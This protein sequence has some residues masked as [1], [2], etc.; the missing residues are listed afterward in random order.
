M[1][2]HTTPA[3]SAPGT[4]LWS[5]GRHR[6]ASPERCPPPPCKDPRK[7]SVRGSHLLSLVSV[8]LGRRSQSSTAAAAA[9][10]APADASR[11]PKRRSLS[12]KSVSFFEATTP[13]A[14]KRRTFKSKR[15]LTFDPVKAAQAK[16]KRPSR[17]SGLL[18]RSSKEGVTKKPKV[19]SEEGAAADAPVYVQE[20]EL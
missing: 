8:V 4:P 14:P 3:D 19:D 12:S 10:P 16:P 11:R 13:V 18:K 6:P 15:Q 2:S 1:T 20:I 7:A 17:L 5:P 9:T